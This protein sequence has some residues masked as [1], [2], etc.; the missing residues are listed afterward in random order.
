MKHTGLSIP[1]RSAQREMV[2]PGGWLL[3]RA[4]FCLSASLSLCNYLSNYLS[5]SLS[6]VSAS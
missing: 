1:G 3:I 2:L 4:A 5:L 6:P